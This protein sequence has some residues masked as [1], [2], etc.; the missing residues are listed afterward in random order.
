MA[1]NFKIKVKGLTDSLLKSHLCTLI[2]KFV[3]IYFLI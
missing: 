3:A 2:L 1:T